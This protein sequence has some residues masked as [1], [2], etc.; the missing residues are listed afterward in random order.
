[1][2]SAKSKVLHLVG[3]KSEKVCSCLCAI[4]YNSNRKSSSS[5]SSIERTG[6]VVANSMLLLM[7]VVVVLLDA[8]MRKPLSRLSKSERMEQYNIYKKVKVWLLGKKLFCQ[9]NQHFPLPPS[10]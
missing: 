1:M 7:V 8:T 2:F 10:I 3:G 4:Q 9:L 6:N 5:T